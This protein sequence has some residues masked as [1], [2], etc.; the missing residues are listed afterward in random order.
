MQDKRKVF[1]L[2]LKLFTSSIDLISNIKI[3]ANQYW[4]W[5]IKFY[6]FEDGCFKVYNL[7]F[8]VFLELPWQ[9]S[10]WVQTWFGALFW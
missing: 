10:H 1:N 8:E 3:Y 9:E 6:V 4:Q 7:P 2:D 5:P